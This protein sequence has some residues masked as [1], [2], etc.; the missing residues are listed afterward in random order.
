[1]GTD[2]RLIADLLAAGQAEGEPGWELPLWTD[3][4]RHIESTVADVKNVGIRWGGAITAGL[5]LREFV[6]E[7]PWAHLDVAGTAFVEQG[8]EYWPRGATGS[9]ARTIVRYIEDQA[10]RP[11]T[12]TSRAKRASSGKRATSRRRG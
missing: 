1:M 9:P 7:I 4:R 12:T 11:A 5:F 10:A 2:R 8:G 3:Y 6:G